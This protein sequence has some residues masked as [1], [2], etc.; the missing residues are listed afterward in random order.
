MFLQAVELNDAYEAAMQGYSGRKVSRAR[1]DF[2][3]L[4]LEA[5]GVIPRQTDSKQAWRDTEQLG[6]QP[7]SPQSATS[8]ADLSS[9]PRGEAD[10][11]S[12]AEAGTPQLSPVRRK[13]YV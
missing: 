3:L 7:A 2:N 1:V 4:C 12:E 5:Q 8:Q 13:G 10:A 6:W 11:E 9:P